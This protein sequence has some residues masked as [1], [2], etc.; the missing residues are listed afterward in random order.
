MGRIR[1]LDH[2]AKVSCLAG[3]ID[4]GMSITKIANILGDSP[5]NVSRFCKKNGIVKVDLRKN[6][7]Q[8]LGAEEALINSRA[9][10]WGRV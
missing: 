2:D 1:K 8:W 7:R 5:G 4:S 9:M 10:R 6:C 3:M